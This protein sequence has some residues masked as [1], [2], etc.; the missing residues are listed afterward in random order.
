MVLPCVCCIDREGL[1]GGPTT[2]IACFD[3]AGGVA[4]DGG[5]S[6]S[7]HRKGSDL[8]AG[9]WEWGVF[10]AGEVTIFTK[11]LANAALV[12][13]GAIPRFHAFEIG[14]VAPLGGRDG[15]ALLGL[16]E[17]ATLLAGVEVANAADPQGRT[18]AGG[19]GSD[20][21][22]EIPRWRCGVI[23]ACVTVG[24]GFLRDGG[25]AGPWRCDA[26]R[27][28]GIH[29]GGTR[30]IVCGPRSISAGSARVHTAHAVG[31]AGWGDTTTDTDGDDTRTEGLGAFV[32][33]ILVG[34]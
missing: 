26:S 4:S 7:E 17:G 12:L 18:G 1:G 19:G 3:G 31:V 22:A 24:V 30:I 2:S 5:A 23:A 10:E 14:S 15:A 28:L 33:K 27:D 16:D 25:A 29:P 34:I 21:W 6:G 9:V 11:D 32:R 20:S 8:K 13:A